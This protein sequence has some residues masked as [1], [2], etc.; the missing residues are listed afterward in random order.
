MFYQVVEEKCEQGI[1]SRYSKNQ[2]I[3]DSDLLQLMNDF[4][5]HRYEIRTSMR[6]KVY[7]FFDYTWYGEKIELY[8]LNLNKIK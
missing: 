3:N 6:E 4:H 2:K 8:Q 7:E 5:N 1:K